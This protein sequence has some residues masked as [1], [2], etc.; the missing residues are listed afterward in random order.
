LT[1]AAWSLDGRLIAYNSCRRE[2]CEIRVA[3]ADGSAQRRVVRLS[4]PQ[5]SFDIGT[6]F[7]SGWQPR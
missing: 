3:S 6:N 1:N 4:A 7:T 2:V 5:M